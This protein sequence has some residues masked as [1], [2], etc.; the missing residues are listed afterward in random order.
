VVL[1]APQREVLQTED[2]P[3]RKGVQMLNIK[4]ILNPK[5]KKEIKVL[6]EVQGVPPTTA[7]RQDDAEEPRARQGE[8][9]V[10]TA[11]EIT[12]DDNRY[13]PIEFGEAVTVLIRA[14][15]EGEALKLAVKWRTTGHCKM[16][17]KDPACPLCGPCGK[18]LTGL[19]CMDSEK[20]LDEWLEA[21]RA[22]P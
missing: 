5:H 14:A 4:D 17:E 7:Q 1:E 18:N 9:S 12:T 22:Q 2:A 19:Y 16:W 15:E 21:W 6:C 11:I 10:K 13:T 20:H 8:M 3:I